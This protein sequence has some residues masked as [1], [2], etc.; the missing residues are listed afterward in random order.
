[1]NVEDVIQ[2]AIDYVKKLFGGSDHRLEEVELK[3]NDA[4]EV[5]IS[6]HEPG[7][8]RLLQLGPSSMFEGRRAAIGID[9]NRMYKDVLVKDGQVKAVHMRQIVVG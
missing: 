6:Y 5:T 9:P 1:M 8:S 3:E 4:F 7:G 2:L